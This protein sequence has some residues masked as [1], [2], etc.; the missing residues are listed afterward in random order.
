MV[1]EPYALLGLSD[2]GLVARF[3]KLARTELIQQCGFAD[4]WDAADQQLLTC[5]NT[6]LVGL[7]QLACAEDKLLSI[8]RS[9]VAVDQAQRAGLAIEVGSPF[10]SNRRFGKIGLI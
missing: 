9:L 7:K 8:Q 5:A 10:L 3:R 2:G 4:V 1:I 6:Q